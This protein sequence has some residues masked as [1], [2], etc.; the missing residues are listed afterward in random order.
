MKNGKFQPIKERSLKR[1]TDWCERYLSN[2]AKESL[3][4]SVLQALSTYAMSVFK[5]SAGLC[6]ELSQIT[7][8]FWWGDE[9]DRRKIHWLAWDK[10]LMPKEKGVWDSGTSAYLIKPSWRSRLGGLSNFRTAYVRDC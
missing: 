8:N 9:N 4:K 1:C 7:R 10:L 6:E 2:A 3:I 5:F